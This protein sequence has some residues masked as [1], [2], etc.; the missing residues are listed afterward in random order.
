[1]RVCKEMTPTELA[2]Y[3]RENA[4]KC[5]LIAKRVLSASERLALVDI[6]QAW[7]DLAHQAEEN[8]GSPREHG[9]DR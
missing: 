5:L 3:Y 8:P 1:M 6:A 4:A 7:T 2:A 9:T